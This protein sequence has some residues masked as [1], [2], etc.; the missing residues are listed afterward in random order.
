MVSLWSPKPDPVK[1]VISIRSRILFEKQPFIKF[2][3]KKG[4][5][6]ERCLVL[7]VQR[8]I[9]PVFQPI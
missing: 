3:L 9:P 4:E 8:L 7:H 2:W 1:V 6:A 5:T